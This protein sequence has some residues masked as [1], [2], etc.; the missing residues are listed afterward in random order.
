MLSISHLNPTARYDVHR[1]EGAGENQHRYGNL[2]PVLRLPIRLNTAGQ[3]ADR[4]QRPE[5]TDCRFE[6]HV[7]TLHCGSAF[8]TTK[9]PTQH[10]KEC[11]VNPYFFSDEFAEVQ[12]QEIRFDKAEADREIARAFAGPIATFA[13]AMSVSILV[14][15]GMM[16]VGAVVA[17]ER[18]HAEQARV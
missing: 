10:A 2:A 11:G 17:I 16:A 15:A 1:R 12:P 7:D 14:L 4:N 6:Q 8:D 9:V 5:E 13:L 3:E 18:Q